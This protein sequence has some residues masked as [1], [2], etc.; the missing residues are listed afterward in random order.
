M[1][2]LNTHAS[3]L[4]PVGNMA[5]CG[6]HKAGVAQAGTVRVR[7]EAWRSD[8]TIST[9][10]TGR[11]A[12]D[13]PARRQAC[14][15]TYRSLLLT[16]LYGDRHEGRLSAARVIGLINLLKTR[17]D[18]RRQCPAGC[19]LCHSK[20]GQRKA[21]LTQ[22]RFATSPSIVYKV[23]LTGTIQ[24]AAFILLGRIQSFGFLSC[25]SACTT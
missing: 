17:Q 13:P 15:P 11:M 10:G 22:M 14:C 12:D 19:Q 1:V 9:L 7:Q 24:H 2:L 5:L 3:H 6:Q 16:K 23:T 20:V 8:R 25:H 18:F 21:T 4:L